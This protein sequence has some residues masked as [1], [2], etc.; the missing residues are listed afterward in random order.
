MSELGLGQVLVYVVELVC[1]L[2]LASELLRQV[3][4]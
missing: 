1:L 2:A 3:R 4:R